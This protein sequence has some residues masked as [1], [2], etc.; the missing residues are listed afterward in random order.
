MQGGEI[1][2]PKIPSI[3]IMDLA[4]AVAP[5]C[6]YK[7]IG[8]R[9]GEKIHEV[10]VP[11]DEAHNT[12]EYRKMYIILPV[13]HYWDPK[14]HYKGHKTLNHGFKYSSDINK[15]WLTVEALQKILRKDEVK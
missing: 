6:K 2:I 7:L 13:F 12:I 8:I 3:R 11:E 10:L 15:D 9:P 14:D 4:K 1:F 5:H